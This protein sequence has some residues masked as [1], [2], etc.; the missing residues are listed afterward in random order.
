MEIIHKEVKSYPDAE[1]Q[2]YTI[3]FLVS[4][5][6]AIAEY[7]DVQSDSPVVFYHVTRIQNYTRILLYKLKS[8]YPEYGITSDNDIEKIVQASALHDIGKIAI[9]DDILTK[10]TKLSRE[11]FDIVKKHTLYGADILDKFIIYED[12][13]YR[14]CYDI[15]KYHHERWDG[16]GYPE[17]LVGEKIPIWAQ[18][19]G[20]ADVYDALVNAKVYRGAF[21]RRKVE[22]MIISGACGSFNPKVIHCFTESLDEFAKI[23]QEYT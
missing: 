7:R 13:F 23:N 16:K 19:V 14:Y 21:D 3:D 9:P 12:E 5:L 17:G 20:I 10:P 11:E 15:C 8:L 18:L 2:Q 6:S 4:L 22:D 1:R